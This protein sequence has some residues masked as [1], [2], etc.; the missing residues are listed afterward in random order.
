[1][2]HPKNGCH[3]FD[4]NHTIPIINVRAIFGHTPTWDNFW[5]EICLTSR[6]LDGLGQI[7]FSETGTTNS[8][9]YN[10]ILILL[11]PFVMISILGNFMQK[12]HIFRTLHIDDNAYIWHSIHNN[13]FKKKHISGTNAGAHRIPVRHNLVNEQIFMYLTLGLFLTVS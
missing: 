10:S 13:K 1:M 3:I 11:F 8:Y 7:F 4:M 5:T 12:S 9:S 2:K 6:T